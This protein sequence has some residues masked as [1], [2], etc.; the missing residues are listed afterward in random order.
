MKITFNLNGKGME[1][2]VDPMS[3]ALD[4]IRGLSLT[5]TKEGCGVGVCGACT[6]MVNGSPVSSCICLVGTLSDK[7]VW[8][9]EGLAEKM[10]ELIDSFVEKEGMQCGIC[11][12]G[13]IVAAAAIDSVG[14]S[15]PEDIKKYMA[16]NLCR[17]TGY[18]TILSAVEEYVAIN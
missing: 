3:L 2:D 13:Q 4:V 16:G 8:T 1:L 18:Q 12:P 9:I 5:G 14:A 10:P 7:D 17:C 15:S 6:I 11:T